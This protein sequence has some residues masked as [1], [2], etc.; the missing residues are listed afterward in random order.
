MISGYDKIVLIYHEI[1][2]SNHFNVCLDL[3][4]IATNGSTQKIFHSNDNYFSG[5]LNI[6]RDATTYAKKSTIAC[7]LQFPQGSTT[8]IVEFN[9][10]SLET[11]PKNFVLLG[12]Q[13]INFKFRF[14]LL[15][16]TLKHVFKDRIPHSIIYI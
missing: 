5:Y 10:R 15:L 12:N 11:D 7:S 2:P 4:D 3:F 1:Y 9:M 16:I 14:D 6:S 8:T 13:Q